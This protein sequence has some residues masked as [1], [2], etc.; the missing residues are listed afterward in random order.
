MV[1]L[2]WVGAVLSAL[3]LCVTAYPLSD[4]DEEAQFV[5]EELG[6]SKHV[7]VFAFVCSLWYFVIIFHFFILSCIILFH[8]LGSG[9]KG[10]KVLYNTG[11]FA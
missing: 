8:F 2:I 5:D 4:N 10:I 7:F 3:F 1:K 11:T 6:Q 9:P